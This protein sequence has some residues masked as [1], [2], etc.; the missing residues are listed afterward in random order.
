MS[1][2][3][4][5]ADLGNVYDDG[6]LSNR[7]MVINGSFTVAQRGLSGGSTSLYAYT[8]DRWLANGSITSWSQTGSQKN[9]LRV[10]T[11]AGTGIAQRIESNGANFVIGNTYTLSFKVN[12]TVADVEIGITFRNGS[13]FLSNV[14]AVTDVSSQV[15]AGSYSTVTYTFTLS[16]TADISTYASHNMQVYIGSSVVNTLDLMEVQLEV[17]DTAT[18]FEHRSYGDELARCQRYYEKSGVLYLTHYS[19][20]SSQISNY[21]YRV[22]K[23]ATPTSSIVGGNAGTVT[24]TGNVYANYLY[25]S[26]SQSANSA[27]LIADAEL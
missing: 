11:Q 22:I 2:A 26:A 15:T 4:Q 12:P 1:K 16:E 5:L 9:V 24:G 6:A 7:N 23:R 13:S 18:P 20:S 27:E 17:G 8:L 19:D 3:R 14:V 21:P 10:V 25:N